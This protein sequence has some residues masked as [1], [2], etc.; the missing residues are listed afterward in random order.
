MDKTQK[1]VAV[2]GLWHLGCTVA[3]SLAKQGHSVMGFDFEK[4]LIENLKNAQMPI[5]EVGLGE[6]TDEMLAKGNLDFTNDFTLLKNYKYIVIG[7]DTP[8]GDDDRPDLSVIKKAVQQIGKYA[9]ASVTIIIMSQVPAG[10][11]REIYNLLYK[12]IKGLEV[13]YNPENLRLSQAIETY[14]NA[15]R[16]IIGITSNECKER[17]KSFYEFYKNPLLFMK[18]ESAELVKHGINS[19]L[20]MSVSFINQLSDLSEKLGG[21]ITEVVLGI[22]SDSR[23]GQKAFLSPG[24]GFAGGTL[25]R[26]LRVL[27]A[28][29]KKYKVSLPL[30]SDVYKINQQRKEILYK[31]L[32]VVLK[33]IK[34]KKV[35]IFGLVYKP[36]TNTLRRSLSLEVGKWLVKQGAEV[37]GFDPILT[38]AKSVLP[39]KLK[40]TP[41][42]AAAGVDVVLIITEW[43]EFKNLDYKKIQQSMRGN[44]IFDT[45]NLL[46]K[47]ELES[48]KFEYYGTGIGGR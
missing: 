40:T 32:K 35:A 5:A 27:E 34:G 12:K 45:K 42:E 24:L 30:F 9:A 20:A 1:K 38:E 36:G 15:D 43:P 7:Y 37:L 14:I 28:L 3:A 46:N 23:I 11:C 26:D 21:N 33:N 6:L 16:Q 44:I 22:K 29:A 19:F 31:K 41:Y 25:G 8:V 17:M 18:L 4:K 39:I 2:I 47:Q 48:L 10:T 13:A